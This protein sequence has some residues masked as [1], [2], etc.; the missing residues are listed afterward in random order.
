M[1]KRL[2]AGF[3]LIELIVTMS[4]AAILIAT[5]VPSFRNMILNGRQSATYNALVSELSY[6]RSEAVKRSTSVALCARASDS[7]C[8]S[9]DDWSDGWL[10]FV[11]EDNN[12][13]VNGTEEILRVNGELE[14][15]Q[16]LLS[17]NFTN[18]G[19]VRY[20]SRGNTDSIGYFVICDD[21]GAESA[22][23]VNIVLTGAIRKAVDTNSNDIVENMAGQDVSCP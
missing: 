8:A 15:E 3:T 1:A 2:N 6:A 20:R 22:K 7:S 9:G 14:D 4:V 17:N 5:G 11:D 10:V 12:G 23:A 18:T 13:S 19:F 16:S 21:R